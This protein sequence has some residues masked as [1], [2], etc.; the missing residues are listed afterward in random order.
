MAIVINQV[1]VKKKLSKSKNNLKWTE[2]K[3][4]VTGGGGYN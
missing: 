2:Y 4:D 1:K 3:V